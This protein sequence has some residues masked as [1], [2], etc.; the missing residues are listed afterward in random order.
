[1][2]SSGSETTAL[3]ARIMGQL[4]KALA[5]S[6]SGIRI[7]AASGAALL[8]VPGREDRPVSAGLLK[9]LSSRGIVS[10]KSGGPY[11]LTSE[12]HQ[13]LRRLL[14]GGSFQDQHRELAVESRPA[15]FPA[16]T[17]EEVVMTGINVA[18]SPLAWLARR[19]DRNGSALLD[20]AQVEAGE[21]L[22][23]DYSFARLM[24][25]M[26]G[27]WRVEAPAA[28]KGAGGGTGVEMTDDVL[29]ARRRVEMALGSLQPVLAR[30]LIDVC[31]HLKGLE[32]VEA[33]RG[34]PARSAKVV[35]QIALDAL[36]E[37]Y[38]FRSVAGAGDGRIRASRQVP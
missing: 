30:L 7:D 33:E 31:C 28:Q 25:S 27:G 34:W 3:S 5:V 22:R 12:G 6:G 18:E 11:R 36:A 8:C 35:L 14:S 29:A 38:G 32:T 2:A 17:G 37:R 26:A 23:A 16:G 10:G 19:R 4:L 13:A 9:G 20:K 21:K 1:M 15:P 24:P